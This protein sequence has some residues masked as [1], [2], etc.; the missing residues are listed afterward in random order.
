MKRFANGVGLEQIVF[1]QHGPMRIRTNKS[2]GQ[3]RRTV[4]ES[5][6]WVAPAARRREQWTH[7]PDGRWVERIV[8]TN[9]GAAYDPAFTNRYVWDGQVLLAV[10]D[11]GNNLVLSFLRGLDL[12]GTLEGAGG[13]GG[14]LWL[15][16]GANGAHFCAYDG[17]GNVAALCA[18]SD[19]SETGRYEYGP[20]GEPLRLT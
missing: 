10:L 7:L 16:S 2:Y 8:S 15:N 17:N 5:R 3:N 1:E 18:A 20:F 6:A 12:S 4:I 9:N 11:D 19:G 14:L 13:V